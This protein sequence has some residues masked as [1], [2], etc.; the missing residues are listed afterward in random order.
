MTAPAALGFSAAP[1]VCA[2]LVAW[3]RWLESER[4]ASRH[5][6]SAYMHDVAGFLDF[7][8]E[9]QGRPPALTDLGDADLSDFRAWLSR[10]AAAGA[11][12]AS[13]ARSLAGLR[14]LFRWLDRSGRLHNPAVGL[15]SSPKSRKPVPRPLT[16]VDAESVLD[17]A[18][19]TPDAP[20]IGRRDRALFTLLYGC[21]LRI[22]EALRLNRGEAAE[23]DTLVVTGKGRKQ[24]MVPVLPAVRQAIRH[25]LDACPYVLEAAAPLFVGVRG[26]RLNAGVAQRQLRQ[27]R[28]LLGLPETA[29]PHALRHSFATHLL[30]DGADLRA[31]QELLGHAS[32]STTQ[33][34][35]EVDAEQLMAVYATAHPRARG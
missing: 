12:A 22:D 15:L 11:I 33:R 31:I 29:T 10:R 8:T 25:Y 9:H 18:G 35:T 28:Q 34:Y 17:E 13:R 26:K 5:T 20:W 4:Q 14:N 16:E 3:R 27:L 23:G 7:L 32:L 6:V 2:A 24:R 21:G 19:E 1:D 30:A